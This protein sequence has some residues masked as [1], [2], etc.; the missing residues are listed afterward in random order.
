[1]RVIQLDSFDQIG[2]FGVRWNDLLKNS[3]DNNIFM[4]WEWLTTWWKYYRTN[5]ELVLLIVEDNRKIIAAAPLMVSTYRLFGFRLGIMEFIGTPAADYHAFMLAERSLSCARAFLSYIKEHLVTW[6]CMALKE[7]PGDTETASVL[8]ASSKAPL[9]LK[10]RPLDLCP[11]ILLPSTFEEYFRYLGRAKRKKLGQ[12]ERRLKR[13][14]KMEIKMYDDIGS[15]EAAMKAF[16]DLHQ[17]RWQAKGSAGLFVDEAF[18]A[19][20]LDVAERFAEREWLRLY[21]LTVDDEPVSAWYAFSYGDKLYSYLSGFDPRFSDYGVGNLIIG[22]L[23]KT[24]I[25]KGFKEFDFMRGGHPYKSQWNT[26]IRRNIE[27]SATRWKPVPKAYEWLVRSNIL[28]S[29]SG[30]LRNRALGAR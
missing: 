8:R 13:E 22:H 19:F 17:R 6:D 27:L 5:R 9:K 29:L 20:H 25:E 28:P 15:V 21:F 23:V 12:W 3:R 24:C 16:F 26:T 14:Y 11:S 18:R 2:E 4:T 7:I 1:M 10:E 30:R